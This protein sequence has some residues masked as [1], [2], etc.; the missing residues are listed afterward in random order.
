[1]RCIPAL[2]AAALLPVSQPVL[3]GIAVSSGTLVI[4]QGSAKAQSLETASSI[5]KAI[6]VLIEGA[7]QG[8]G[9]LV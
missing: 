5:A 9:V 1:M 2:V 6:T 3:L 8:S 4:T 7:T